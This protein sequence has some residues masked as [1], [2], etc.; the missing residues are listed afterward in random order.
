MPKS[1]FIKI[2]AKIDVRLK[3]LGRKVS[4][5]GRPAKNFAEDKRV[6]SYIYRL[7]YFTIITDGKVSVAGF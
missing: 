4:R 2:P 5:A 6:H 3:I 1:H 7:G